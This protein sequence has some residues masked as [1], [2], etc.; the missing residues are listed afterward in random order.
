MTWKKGVSILQRELHMS[1][2]SNRSALPLTG[3]WYSTTEEQSCSPAARCTRLWCLL[4]QVAR[5]GDTGDDAGQG[6]VLTG[7]A[8]LYSPLTNRLT[9]C[10]LGPGREQTPCLAS[11]E[12][13]T[14]EG[15][16]GSRWR[17][18]QSGSGMSERLTCS[19]CINTHK[20]DSCIHRPF[21]FILG[22][23]SIC[24]RH[25][26]LSTHSN[27]SPFTAISRR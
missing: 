4:C 7:P 22:I 10:S 16:T 24:I 21:W 12:H 23:F 13:E 26:G 15:Q 2:R 20:H 11:F 25:T 6:R 8:L 14:N 19:S 27:G 1:H 9:H 18:S 3:S 17:K 5:G